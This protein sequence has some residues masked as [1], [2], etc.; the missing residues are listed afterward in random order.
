[1]EE[2]QELQ[3][4]LSN[5]LGQVENVLAS[6]EN[7]PDQVAGE[8]AQTLGALFSR[9]EE[10][11]QITPNIPPLEEAMPSSN[12]GAFNYD[13]RKQKLF[14][15]FLDKY[16]NR[17]G[18]IY[19]YEGVPFEIFDLFR[20]G[21]YPAKTTGKNRWGKWFKGKYP[22]IGAAMYGW[23]KKGNFPYHKLT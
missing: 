12:I 15:Q 23:L 6:G 5:F 20:K 7:I 21:S 19:S 17:Q 9:I 11:K 16:P 1:M 2:L 22:S 4:L 3:N 18:P 14:V 10:L 13:P 8:I